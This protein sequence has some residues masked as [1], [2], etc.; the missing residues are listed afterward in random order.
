MGL[1]GRARVAV[2]S[3]DAPEGDGRSDLPPGQRQLETLKVKHYG[4]IPTAD[5]ARWTMQFSGER[6][7]GGHADEIGRLL[8]T[9]LD[10][11]PRVTVRTGLHCASGWSVLGL[12]WEGIPASALLERFPPPPGTLGVLAYAE[13]GYST[14]VALADLMEPTTLVATH[15]DGVPLPAEHGFPARLVVPHLYAHKSPKWFRGWEYLRTQRRG[16]WEER[17]YHV[18]G[19][20]WLEQRYSY[21]E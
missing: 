6:A 5:P 21:T 2:A 18:G 7:D 4:R 15:L 14:N 8:A 16:F 20:P 12:V 1:T 10:E 19:D 9:E 3:G 17:G 11:M 13:Y